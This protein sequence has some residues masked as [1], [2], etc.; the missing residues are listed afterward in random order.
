MIRSQIRLIWDAARQNKQNGMWAQRRLRS[1]SA[2]A[3][4]MKKTWILSYPLSASEDS[5]IRLSGCPGWSESSLCA[6]A[7]LLVL[8]CCGWVIHEPLWG[9]Q[10]S[11]QHLLKIRQQWGD[12]DFENLNNLVWK[13][14]KKKKK[15]TLLE[16]LK[17]FWNLRCILRCI[18]NTDLVSKDPVHTCI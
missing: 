15:K 8:S 13:K 14:K 5:V 9:R 7:T 16:T 6:H 3:V 10:L 1:A 11:F 12:Y 2:S 17:M 4:R 18:N